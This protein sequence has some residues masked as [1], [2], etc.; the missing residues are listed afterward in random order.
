MQIKQKIAE[1]CLF[2]AVWDL[3]VMSSFSLMFSERG[4]V[5]LFFAS[6]VSPVY[7]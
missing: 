6:V 7:M 4:Q 3:P 1:V 2:E 5:S